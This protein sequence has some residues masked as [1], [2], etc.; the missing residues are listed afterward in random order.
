MP[1]SADLR[2]PT[3]KHFIKKSYHAG[4]EVLVISECPSFRLSDQGSSMN[5]LA[6]ALDS[7]S[8]ARRIC[9]SRE[10]QAAIPASINERC[11]KV[12]GIG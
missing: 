12:N 1:G 3:D 11:L 6:A 9:L 4:L 2:G 10:W 5:G 7:H 8:T